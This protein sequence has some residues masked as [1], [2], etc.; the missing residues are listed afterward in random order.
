MAPASFID[1]RRF[2]NYREMSEYMKA[3]RENRHP[4]DPESEEKYSIREE[5]G[6]FVFTGLRK[7]EGFSLR[8]FRKVFGEEFF[9]VYDMDIVK[10]YKGMLIYN[11][12]R[13]YLSER[14]MDI[15]NRIMAE[16]V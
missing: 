11:D 3:V 4:I 14:G 15:S 12:D 16:F 2:N 9:D 8:Q 1:G 10:R 13:L 7:A 6:I 5:M